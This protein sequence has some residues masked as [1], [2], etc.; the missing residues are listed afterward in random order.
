MK[1]APF[2]S[3]KTPLHTVFNDAVGELHSGDDQVPPQE[4]DNYSTPSN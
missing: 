4:A 1:D 2:N 3:A